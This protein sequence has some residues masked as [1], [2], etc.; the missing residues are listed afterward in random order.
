MHPSV[1]IPR[2]LKLAIWRYFPEKI[3]VKP[4]STTEVTRVAMK[5]M[6]APSVMVRAPR[7]M[8]RVMRVWM[9]VA[10][11]EGSQEDENEDID[12]LQQ[13]GMSESTESDP[14]SEKSTNLERYTISSS[15]ESESKSSK[16]DEESRESGDPAVVGNSTMF[17][18]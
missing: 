11:R 14:E 10:K 4:R 18:E 13:I 1:Q 17:A 7:V 3:D 8:K 12:A 15:D 9:R 16:K 2:S 5:V 6:R